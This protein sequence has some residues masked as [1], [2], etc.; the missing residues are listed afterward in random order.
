[1]KQR[2][3]Q[4][5][6]A[7]QQPKQQAPKATSIIATSNHRYTVQLAMNLNECALLVMQYNMHTQTID[8]LGTHTPVAPDTISYR[9]NVAPMATA[10]AFRLVATCLK[11]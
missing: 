5:Q 3:A 9:P 7:Q 2:N 6:K 4:Q 11:H 10:A 8:Q 1:M